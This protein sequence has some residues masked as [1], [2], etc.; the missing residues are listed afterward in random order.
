MNKKE[1]LHQLL[2]ERIEHPERIAEI[3]QKIRAAFAET[4]ALM[5]LDMSGFSR[6]TIRYGIIHFLA[7][8]HRMNGI[9]TPAVEEYGGHV[10]K[11]DAD[12]VFAVFPD[13]GKALDASQ[14]ILKR[15][16]AVNTGL[17]EELDL[18]ASMGIGY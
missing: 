5:V 2:Q 7:M 14:D 11:V 16:E 18:Y 1:E 3:D 17:P 4:H 13:V 9:V 15:L 6:L 8:I 12:D 10:V